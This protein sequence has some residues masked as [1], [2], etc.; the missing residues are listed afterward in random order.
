MQQIIL[1]LNIMSKFIVSFVY[2]VLFL[3]T[4]SPGSKHVALGR[5]SPAAYFSR[6]LFVWKE[7]HNDSYFGLLIH[8]IR[9]NSTT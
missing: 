7:R 5:L 9:F 4:I 3:D 2:F 8:D 1:F 6:L